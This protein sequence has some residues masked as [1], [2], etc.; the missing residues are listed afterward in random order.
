VEVEKKTNNLFNLINFLYRFFSF[1]YETLIKKYN[2][3]KQH[4][5]VKVSIL[6]FNKITTYHLPCLFFKKMVDNALFI[7]HLF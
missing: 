2:N 7:Y 5:K 1:F 4:G 6:F 3:T